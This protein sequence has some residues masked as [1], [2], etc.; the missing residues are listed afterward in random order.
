[1]SR[2]VKNAEVEGNF[3]QQKQTNILAE[4]KRNVRQCCHSGVHLRGLREVTAS[5]TFVLVQ[6]DQA[7]VKKNAEDIEAAKKAGLEKLANTVADPETLWQQAVDLVTKYTKASASYLANIVEPEAPDW[8]PPDGDEAADAQTDDEVEEIKE[9]AA[10]EESEQPADGAD[11]PQDEPPRQS[12]TSE[13]P[14]APAAEAH[15]D[16]SRKLLTY[17][18]SSAGQEF[19]KGVELSRP[20]PPTDDQIEAGAV[21]DTPAITFQVI[22]EKLPVLTIP[23]VAFEPR[24][25]FFRKF[26]R[27][28]AYQACAVTLASGEYRQVLCADTLLPEGSGRPFTKA[29]QDFIWEVALALSRAADAA[30]QRLREHSMMSTGGEEVARMRARIKDVYQPPPPPPEAEPE[31]EA[32]GGGLLGRCHGSAR[33][34]N[35]APLPSATRRHC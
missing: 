11:A 23:N 5:H 6:E 20:A 29:E 17:C 7:T 15:F 8:A 33:F 34:M 13:P 24:V 35:S 30:Q 27:V 21:Q 25:K 22:D 4:A 9:A 28:G 16:Y 26:P 14:P 32:A 1:M 10:P 3:Y 12:S 19:I 31:A 18:V 2:Y